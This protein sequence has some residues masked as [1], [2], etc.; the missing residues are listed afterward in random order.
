M[1]NTSR[2]VS[3]LLRLWRDADS[4]PWRATLVDGQSGQS[5]SF[6]DPGRLF[7]YLR[8]QMEDAARLEQDPSPATEQTGDDG[9]TERPSDTTV[10]ARA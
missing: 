7:A 9:R 4:G 8:V 10:N 5:R 6:A 1:K 3:Y 2:Y